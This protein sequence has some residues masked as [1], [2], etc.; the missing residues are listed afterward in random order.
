MAVDVVA[1]SIGIALYIVLG[2][3]QLIV[4]FVLC[5]LIDVRHRYQLNVEK[6]FHISFLLFAL[7]RITWFALRTFY[8]E[9]ILTLIINRLGFCV[10]FTSFS[11]VIFHWASCFHTVHFDR[12][13]YTIP[14]AK[15]GLIFC[16]VTLYLFQIVV[17]LVLSISPSNQISNLDEANIIVI[18][19]SS[20]LVSIC[21]LI[22]GVRMYVYVKKNSIQSRERSRELYKIISASVLFALCHM[23]RVVMFVIQAVAGDDTGTF[24][25]DT[26]VGTFFALAYFIP[27]VITSSLQMYA[28]TTTRR[29]TTFDSQYIENLYKENTDDLHQRYT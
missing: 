6:I 29:R 10:L 22:Y 13:H 18:C 12:S 28:I 23:L 7:L 14:I 9:G 2:V 17:F 20:L 5:L 1:D 24:S 21:L 11:I 16:N 27:E 25:S 15:W 4:F 19:M 3:V 8:V 26:T